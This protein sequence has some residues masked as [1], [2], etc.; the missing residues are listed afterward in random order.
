MVHEDA[1]TDAIRE[2]VQAAKVS[3]EAAR[4]HYAVLAEVWGE[5]QQ[6]A[7]LHAYSGA[8]GAIASDEAT[9]HV[10]LG[11]TLNTLG[12]GGAAVRAYESALVHFPEDVDVL[13]EYA[14]ALRSL[15]KHSEAVE[16]FREVRRSINADVGGT[17]IQIVDSLAAA[18]RTP[19]AVEVLRE[20]IQ[21]EPR[22]AWHFLT[23]GLLLS[24]VGQL[25]EAL[26]AYEGA[27]RLDPTFE[28]ARSAI[29]RL[30]V[31]AQEGA[32]GREAWPRVSHTHQDRSDFRAEIA[33]AAARVS[34]APDDAE[35]H[36]ALAKAIL[37]EEHNRAINEIR[38]A[39]QLKPEYGEA[40]LWMGVVLQ[41]QGWL[42]EA[43]TEFNLALSLGQQD[44]L[45]LK[46]LGDTYEKL[47]DHA[48]AMRAYTKYQEL[49]ARGG[50]IFP[51]S[52]LS[53]KQKVE[54][55]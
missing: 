29:D 49:S 37:F 15:G 26:A 18:G 48:A 1:L 7:A 54:A 50:P 47:G 28:R 21:K 14:R 3:P 20:L 24:E 44:W 32:D 33:A 22:N 53:W 27:L 16:V 5:T 45:A 42:T 40:H 13:T 17:T 46:P 39:I 43:V 10:Y 30:Q 11:R 34:Q 35:A 41:S 25:D 38:R 4:D 9:A 19:E 36:L 51:I 31:S 6:W 12:S 52:S 8:A 2:Y 55:Q 23:L